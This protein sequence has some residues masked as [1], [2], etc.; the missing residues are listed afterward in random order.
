MVSDKKVDVKFGE[1]LSL[2]RKQDPNRMTQDSLAEM[3]NVSTRTVST[4]ETG[5]RIPSVGVIAWLA[6]H[7]KVS[8]DYIIGRTDY[9]D[10][11]RKDANGIPLE[12]DWRIDLSADVV[13]KK[14]PQVAQIPTAETA[15]GDFSETERALLREMMEN[16]KSETAKKDSTG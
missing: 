12:E 13:E 15:K 1:R 9:P 6:D 2:L 16:Y 3:M 4:W 5:E 10:F 14:N 7:F 8:M 11:R